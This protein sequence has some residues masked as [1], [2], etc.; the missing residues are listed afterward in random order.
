MI[1]KNKI[2]QRLK[3]IYQKNKIA[4][5]FLKKTIKKYSRNQKIILYP[6][7]LIIL[8]NPIISQ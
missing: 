3:K 5:N 4:R 2:K 1:I 8:N 6:K 7:N